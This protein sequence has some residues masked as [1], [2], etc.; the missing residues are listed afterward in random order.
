MPSSRLTKLLQEKAEALKKRRQTAEEQANAAQQRYRE[1]EELSVSLEEGPSRS[2]ALKELVR[3]SDWEEVESA[4]KEFSSYLERESGPGLE[5]R[6]GELRGRAERLK[7]LQSPVPESALAALGEAAALAQKGEWAETSARMRTGVEAIRACEASYATSLSDRLGRLIDWSHEAPERRA[8][9]EGRLKNFFEA[10]N[11]GQTD[12]PF[13]ETIVAI[14]GDLPSATVLRNRIRTSAEALEAA[15]RE[16]GVPG[17]ELADALSADKNRPLLDWP[18]SCGA[19]ETA[20][21]GVATALRERVGG[22]LDGFR[23]TLM[24]LQDQ[25]IDPSAPLAT[26]ERVGAELGQAPPDRIPQLLSEARGTVEEPVLGVVAALLDEVRPRLVEARRLGRN[27]TEVFSAMNRAREALRLR[28]YGEALAAAQEALDRSERLI[29]DLDAARS[30]QESLESLLGRL[31]AA[32][33][34]VAAY[35]VPVARSGE[36][37][38]RADLASARPLIAE[39]FRR[40]GEESLKEVGRQLDAL[41]RLGRLG[42]ELGF[43]PNGFAEQVASLRKGLDEGQIAEA[44]EAAARLSVELRAAAGPYVAHRIEEVSKG[45]EE[46]PD[47]AL[48]APVRRLL[49][50]SDVSL[51]VKEDLGSSIDQLRRAEREFSVVFAQHASALVEGLE[52]ERKLLGSMGGAGDEMQRQ[53][54]EVQQ[55]FNMGE[56]VKAF[57]AS[58]EIRTRARQQ[59]LVRSEEALSHAKLALVELGKMGLDTAALRSHLDR[60]AEAIKAARDLD[61]WKSASETQDEAGRLRR[62]AQAVLDRTDEVKELVETLRGGGTTVEGYGEELERARAS[63]QALDFTRARTQLDALFNRLE[64]EQARREA[65]RLLDEADALANDARRLSVPIEPLAERLR[66]AREAITA[67][68]GHDSW[69]LARTAHT[70]LVQLLRPVLE[71]NVRALERDVEIARTAELDVGPVV[72]Q[73]TELRRRLSLSVPIG[74]SELLETARSRFHETRGFLEHAERAMRRARDAFNQAEVVRVDVRAFRPR[75]ERVERHLAERDYARTIE[76]AS[77]LERELSQAAHHTV[78]NALANFQGVVSHARQRGAQTALAEN[79]LEQARGQ[80]ERARPLEA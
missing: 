14:E 16:L 40:L 48:A 77:T 24:A 4:A 7:Q 1:L 37:L 78:A 18:E 68:A 30:E 39:T 35:R 56:F 72:E 12:L 76:L 47:P 64:Q 70:D 17:Q 36:M 21:A 59:Q 2:E 28:I 23:S 51:R 20:S 57:R 50:D 46:I 8:A 25:G 27:A 9:A 71:E 38:A 6:L 32:H 73:L 34:S 69:N 43:T 5:R 10:F 75:L 15:A 29:E 53:I 31:E 61:G 49:A 63:Y 65:L 55:I 52:E 22:T 54:D 33:V 26:L 66:R 13:A 79:L 42:S 44:A 67:H 74:I 11:N 3:R 62:T 19:M 80:L 41:E 45:L 58:Q 60:S